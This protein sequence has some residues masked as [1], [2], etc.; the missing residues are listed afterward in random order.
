MNKRTPRAFATGFMVLVLVGCSAEKKPAPNCHRAFEMVSQEIDALAKQE[1]FKKARAEAAFYK[2]CYANRVEY[3]L[4]RVEISPM[5]AHPKKATKKDIGH[6]IKYIDHALAL[7]PKNGYVKLLKSQ[8]LLAQKKYKMSGRL[9]ET[10][11]R[12]AIADKKNDPNLLP[13]KLFVLEFMP[14]Y[15][16]NMKHQHRIPH[17]QAQLQPYLAWVCNNKPKLRW[18]YAQALIDASHEFAK[19]NG[20][21]QPPKSTGKISKNQALNEA[22]AS[23]QPSG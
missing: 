12:K 1:Q 15:I 8:F 10:G 9:Y 3:W 23:F 5:A 2:R 17:A 4:T 20:Q 19:A 11:L 7:E 16:Y 21:K 13:E 14:S 18:H 6:A 22:C